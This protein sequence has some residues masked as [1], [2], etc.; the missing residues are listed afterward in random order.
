VPYRKVTVRECRPDDEAALYGLARRSFGERGGWSDHRTV[1]VICDETVFVAE[2]DDR[3]AGFVALQPG[4]DVVRI[5]QLLVSPEHQGEGIGHQLIEWAEGYAIAQRA[6]AL[7]IVVEDD[8]TRALDF[9]RR[10]GFVGVEPGLLELTLP[11]D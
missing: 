1:G 11:Q 7:R 10:A 2:L 6:R 4:D 9:Y 3:P 8:N 5:D